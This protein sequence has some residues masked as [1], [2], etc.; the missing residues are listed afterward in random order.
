MK[1]FDELR[2][3][4]E[5]F[6]TFSPSDR[7]LADG[8]RLY[9]DGDSDGAARAWRRAD[10]ANPYFYLIV[11]VGVFDETGDEAFASKV[12]QALIAK[13]LAHV[14]G[15]HPAHVREARRSAKRGDLARAK[16]LAR[17]VGDAWSRAD[18][19]VPAVAEMQALLEK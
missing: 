18:V 10:I 2:S 17:I 4:D 16:E 8:A 11:D 1:R 7:P 13:K 15:A 5:F 12:D 19:R 14:A 3:R 6:G 9:V